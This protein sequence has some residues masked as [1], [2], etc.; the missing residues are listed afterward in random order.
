MIKKRVVITGIG[1]IAPNGIGKQA[2]W[3]A[4]ADGRSGIKPITL[5]DTAFFKTKTAGECSDFNA[6]EFLGAKGLRNLDRATK[7]LLSAAKLAIEDAKLAVTD[8]N[9]DDVGVATG[10][11]LSSLWD[12]A[13]FGKEVHVE[14][15]QFA[16][17]GLFAPT[18][19][20]FPSSQ[21]SIWY[22]IKGFNTTISTGFTAGLDSLKYAFDSIQAG[23][24]NAVLAAGVEALSFPGFVG[25]NKI[26]FLAGIKG[27][28][29]CCPFD[30][31]RNG[32]I[33]GEGAAVLVVEDEEFAKARKAEILAE[34]LSVESTFDAFRAAK[35]S[36]KSEG[37][38]ESMSRA[39]KKSGLSEEEI[40]CIFA[41]ANSVPQQDKLET[42][43]IKKV[44]SMYSKTIPISALKS[45]LGESVSSAGCFQVAA[46]AGALSADFIPPTINYREKD[47]ECDL[48]YV[49]NVSRKQVLNNVL[50]NCFGPGGNNAS[51]VITKYN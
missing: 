35:Y 21:V 36:P 3:D 28:E 29:V 13:E 24:A 19:M 31:R 44:F 47:P 8:E 39:I 27:E 5:F 41:A 6:E 48:D 49:P 26:D 40:D 10:T 4:L 46:S 16:S 37:L 18:T 1:V 33:L 32:I 22:K 50:I 25:F 17:P 9:T 51:A 45:M 43:A 12:L 7:L 42:E 2:F 34:V 15:P 14:G 11:T 20:N 23:R 38:I 30:K